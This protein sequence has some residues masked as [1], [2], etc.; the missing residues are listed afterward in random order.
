MVGAGVLAVGL[1]LATTAHAQPKSLAGVAYEELVR[2][3]AP[4]QAMPLLIALHYSGGSA[5]ESFDNYDQVVGP[6]RILVPLG[7][8]PKRR[9]LSYFPIDYYQRSPTE[10]LRIAR[11]TSDRLALFVAA[12]A[13]L[14]HAQPVVSGISQGGDL[15]LMLAVDHPELIKAAFPLAAVIPEGLTPG[16][17]PSR[18][19]RP[20]IVVMQGEDDPIVEVS[21]T[22]SRVAAL[23]RSLP[24]VL[25]TY[26]GL[27]H[28]ISDAMKADYTVAI[29]AALRPGPES[30]G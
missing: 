5:A 9:G 26:P 11:A 7:A 19:R 6:V 1:C 4:D 27:G 28:D 29:G 13:A 15:S 22:R 20:C 3:A 24:I 18:G 16:P 8:Y 2:G 12:A 17:S 21:R 23:S 14:H 25:K 10:Q 30:C